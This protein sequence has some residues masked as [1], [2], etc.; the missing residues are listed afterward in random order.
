MKVLA[1]WLHGF[2]SIEEV[3][4]EDRWF[5]YFDNSTCGRPFCL[6]KWCKIVKE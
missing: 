1:E 2:K 6:K 5:Y 3:T 4:R